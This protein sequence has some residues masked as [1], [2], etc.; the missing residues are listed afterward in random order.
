[1]MA[2]IINGAADM[3]HLALLNDLSEVLPPEAK[4]KY[5]LLRDTNADSAAIG[6][7]LAERLIE[8]NQ[9]RQAASTRI[10]QIRGQRGVDADHPEMVIQTRNLADADAEI[11]RINVRVML[12][13]QTAGPRADLLRNID[14]W[15]R[16]TTPGND[17][18]DVELAEPKLLR[19]ETPATAVDRLQRRLRELGADR[20]RVESAPFPSSYAKA[21]AANYIKQI[22]DEAARGLITSSLTEHGGPLVIDGKIVE[23]PILFPTKMVRGEVATVAGAGA[24]LV[25]V[26]DIIGLMALFCGPAMLAHINELVDADAE[27]KIA[28]LPAQRAEQLAVIKSDYQHA[29]IEEGYWLWASFSAGVIVEPRATMSPPAFLGVQAVPAT[30]RSGVDHAEVAVRIRDAAAGAEGVPFTPRDIVVPGMAPG[31]PS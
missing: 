1:M 3:D 9:R 20:N 26:P 14:R 6:H 28:L 22:A 19:G 16:Q 21:V 18:V 10:A 2:T 17:I 27:D 23:P 24:T 4:R 12:H 30:R 25:E 8:H 31:L 7:G 13:N 29:E 11:D 15:I 5:L